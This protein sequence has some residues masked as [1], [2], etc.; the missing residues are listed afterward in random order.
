LQPGAFMLRVSK[1]T[2]LTSYVPSG[3]NLYSHTMA[4]TM[5]AAA[6]ALMLDSADAAFPASM[7]PITP[8]AAV[9]SMLA[10]IAPALLVSKV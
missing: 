7:E 5:P 9:A 4:P 1:I 10:R 3:F 2:R 8:A 6:S